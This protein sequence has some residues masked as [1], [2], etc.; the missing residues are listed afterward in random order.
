MMMVQKKRV[1]ILIGAALAVSALP[2]IGAGT[3]PGT[4]VLVE[5][6]A[7]A[8]AQPAEAKT[9]IPA[10]EFQYGGKY[11]YAGEPVVEQDGK[12]LTVAVDFSSNKQDD[13]SEVKLQSVKE[14]DLAGKNA[15]HFDVLVQ[16]EAMTQG[17]FKTKLYAKVGEQEVINQTADI[18]LGK[19]RKEK[20]GVLRVP[21]QVNFTPVE[22]KTSYFCLS[23]VGS[24]TDYKGKLG[25]E[26]LYL[27]REK[28]K[29]GYVTRKVYPQKQTK[30]SLAALDIPQHVK[31]S[32]TQA[33]PETAGLMAY[34]RGLADSSYILYGHQ[35]DLTRKA[36]KNM[37]GM[38]DTR[39]VTG[40]NAAVMGID[41]LALTGNE[42]ELTPEEE[43][44]G[45]TLTD[46]LAA[47]Y[48][49]AAKKGVILTMSMH[50]PNFAKVADRPKVNGHYDY[51]GYSPNDLSGNVV[52]RILPGGD[53]NEVYRGYLDMVAAFDAKLQQ[54]GV[55]LLFRPFHE[56][57]GSWFWWGASSCSPS[58][59]KNLFRYTVDYLREEKGLHNLL[60]IYSPNG[61][62]VKDGDY[63][64]RYPGDAW[65]DMLGLDFYHQ[66]P[67]KGDRWMQA[68]E[69]SLTE[70]EQLAA[71]HDKVA[72]LS[73]VGIIAD[74][75]I[76]IAR[77]GNQRLKWYDE[78]LAHTAH[79]KIPYLLTWAD[80]DT[81]NFCQPFLVDKNRGHELIDSF[82]RFY[83][84][85][86]SIFEGDNADWQTLAAEAQPAV[87]EAGYLTAP[88]SFAHLVGAQTFTAVTKGTVGKVELALTPK[89]AASVRFPMVRTAVG[90][91]QADI[92]EASLGSLGRTPGTAELLLD[93]KTADQV[94]VLF[95]MPVVKPDPY[96]VDDF[97]SYYGDDG[98]LAGAYSKNCGNGSDVTWKLSNEHEAGE[99]GLSFHYHIA[100][101]GYAGIVKQLKGVDWSD[102]NAVEF[103]IHPD[104]RGQKL[105]IQLNSNGEDFEV[106]L[107]KLAKETAPQKVRLPF[108]Q[109][110]G[111]NGGQFDK[112]AVQHFGIYCN[113]LSDE[114]V[115]SVMVFDS[116]RA[117]K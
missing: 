83:N 25:I 66:H 13:W 46:K 109:F 48:L 97:E 103:W 29:D 63:M 64:A 32:D 85:P 55:P 110:V 41:A 45:L 89:N 16:P 3:E 44:A 31:L 11:G 19:G 108:A 39:D 47:I 90:K 81:H 93:G 42:L 67:E 115:D 38:S 20:D 21:V 1:S 113:S 76:C 50:M 107:S 26:H 82:T 17:G 27:S 59:F 68:L 52:S 98:L 91:W 88:G 53:L 18:D 51:G 4:V 15:M 75:G 24:R 111:K 35:N 96:V 101:G 7:E 77:T 105:I 104:G 73:E 5:R 80:F 72:T 58:E 49:P 69:S 95:N 8:A 99:M 79:H 36:G 9:E 54:A 71:Q 100:K 12:G 86:Q 78:L 62:I 10:E 14:I 23:L 34:F 61:P 94:P 40:T 106:D 56:N 2:P 74:N 43:R 60:T 112:T 117:V 65:V 70:V 6:T 114:T 84:Q 102:A 22:G 30:L 28:V 92:P 57:N 33:S 116:I 37:P 87:A